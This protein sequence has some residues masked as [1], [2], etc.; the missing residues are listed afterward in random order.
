MRGDF[1][2]LLPLRKHESACVIFDE[3]DAKEAWPETFHEAILEIESLWVMTGQVSPRVS[4]PPTQGQGTA[5]FIDNG[6]IAQ[7]SHEA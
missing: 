7:D 3:V 2:A 1:D 5:P 4:H 6:Y